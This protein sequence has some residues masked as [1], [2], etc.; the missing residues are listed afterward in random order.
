MGR[1]SPAQAG[2]TRILRVRAAPGIKP[3]EKRPHLG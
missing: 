2:L 1:E 3:C